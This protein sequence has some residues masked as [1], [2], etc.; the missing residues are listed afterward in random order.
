MLAWPAAESRS[1]RHLPGR[2]AGRTLESQQD[3]TRRGSPDGV[4][5]LIPHRL[6]LAM[7]SLGRMPGQGVGHLEPTGER[8]ERSFPWLERGN[9]EETKVLKVSPGD[10]PSSSFLLKPKDLTAGTFS[11][12]LHVVGA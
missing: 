10:V 11:L 1:P 7:C 2:R 9:S 5:H 3:L 8:A 4:S 12:C 6:V